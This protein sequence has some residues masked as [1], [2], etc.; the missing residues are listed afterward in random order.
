MPNGS[1]KLG[2]GFLFLG[3][4]FG[5]GILRNLTGRIPSPSRS[6]ML[7]PKITS[8]FSFILGDRFES[9]FY[10]LITKSKIKFIES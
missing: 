6:Q 8:L 2:A 1:T 5:S 9:K 10:F 7:S 3:K 4:A